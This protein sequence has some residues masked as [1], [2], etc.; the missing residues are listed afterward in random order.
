MAD[1]SPNPK[2]VAAGRANRTR[3]GP[4]TPAGRAR[5]RPAALA[6]QPWQHATGPRTAVGRARV[7]EN[8]KQRQRGAIS[9]RAAR[10]Q[11][12]E[13]RALMQAMRELRQQV[14]AWLAAEQRGE[15]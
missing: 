6:Q 1:A 13:V 4:L 2:R 15:G 12:I 8:G 5:L 11:R 9:T 7:A 10:A 14:E 3:R